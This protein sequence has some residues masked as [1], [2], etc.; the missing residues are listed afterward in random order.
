MNEK[1]L[2]MRLREMFCAS[3]HRDKGVMILLFAVK[4]ADII[5]REKYAAQDILKEAQL[6]ERYVNA[7]GKG[8]KLSK[9][10]VAK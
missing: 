2:G 7:F 9:Y 10:V 5:E 4:Y 6:P 1:E 3:E 8:L